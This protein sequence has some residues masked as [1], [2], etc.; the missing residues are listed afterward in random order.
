MR[1]LRAGLDAVLVEVDTLDE[2]LA[3]LGSLHEDPP[4][5]VTDLVPGART[6]LLRYVPARTTAER[7]AQQVGRLRPGSTT[8]AAFEPAAGEPTAG[9]LVEVPV[10]YD[11]EDLAEVA[12]LRG[13]ST[14]EV[15]GR[16]T[17]PV[18][19]VAFTGFAPGF[20][21]LSGGDPALRVP[22][23]ETPRTS[24]PAGSVAIAGEFSGVY[25]RAGPGG[26][27]LI[28]RTDVVLFDLDR[29]PPALLRP[30][31]RVRFL[32][33]RE[34]VRAR[35]TA[36]GTGSA[37]LST[38]AT[39]PTGQRPRGT[40]EVLDPGAQAL[41]QDLGR[42]GV[43]SLGV[44]PSGAMDRGALRRAN[45]LVGNPPAATTVEAA[46]GG[47]TLRAH[48]DVVVA[49]AGAPAS[50]TVAGRAFPPGT[51]VA[52]DDGETLELGAPATGV[53]TYVAVR[54][55]LDV[56]VVLGS[57]SRD[58]LAGLGPEPL[59]GGDRLAV[60]TDAVAAV[61]IEEVAPDLPAPGETVTLDVVL[62][63]RTDWF[64]PSALDLFIAQDWAVK[65]SNRVGLRLAGE[66]PLER[67]DNAELP[68]EGT[69]RGALQVP[70]D[71]QPVLFMADH[72]LTGGYPVAGAVAAYDLDRAAQL[73]VGASVRFRIA[74]SFAELATT[75]QEGA[76]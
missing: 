23:R 6:V 31:G 70:P 10:V 61:A 35:P 50:V 36:T 11:G 43:A 39:Q 75:E 64:P 28:G 17:A 49:T 29:E 69:V 30:G 19:S 15:V 56:P 13:L 26:W 72:P 42:S 66:V 24:I 51:A 46:L 68:S 38:A 65:R 55:G 4:D 76:R 58:V 22:R 53:Y 8:P 44:S 21:Y 59:R 18:Y 12:E 5:G 9:E 67:I 40:L 7:L 45:R 20:A 41:L 60:G 57:G 71:G 63:P 14:G 54:G 34:E 27:R 74:I 37:R 73:P 16:H 33:V 3:L 32:A 2:A 1:V 25:P 62:G 47:L 52:V 48:G